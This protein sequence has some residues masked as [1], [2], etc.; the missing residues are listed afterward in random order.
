MTV[1]DGR[2][3]QPILD[4]PI[5]TAG[6]SQSSPLA[7]SIEGK[8][9]DLFMYFT[10]DCQG[11]EGESSEFQFFQGESFLG[12]FL[13]PFHRAAYPVEGFVEGCDDGL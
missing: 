7:I 13:A 10:L 4:A 11:H 3:G 1:L 12:Y 9:H 8:G 5:R 6:S 2:T